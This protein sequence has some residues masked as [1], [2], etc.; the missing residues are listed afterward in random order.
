MSLI[1]MPE[2]LERFK[3]RDD[4]K[5]EVEWSQRW[6]YKGFLCQIACL[7]ESNRFKAYGRVVNTEKHQGSKVEPDFESAWKLTPLEAKN[8]LQRYINIYRGVL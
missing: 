3:S 8:E 5:E 1:I 6:Q 2:D 7:T 4:K